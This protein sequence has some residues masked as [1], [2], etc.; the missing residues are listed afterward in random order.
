MV[1]KLLEPF[2]LNVIAFDPFVSQEKADSLGL[3]VKM[4]SLEEVFKESDVVSLHTPLLAATIG[5]IE[6]KHFELMKPSSTFINT[7]R[8]AIIK[9][10]EMIEV[11]KKRPDIYVCLDVTKSRTTKG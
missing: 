7:S 1:I 5:M 9:E 8:G 3:K 11:L 6:G 2:D 4:C 10:N